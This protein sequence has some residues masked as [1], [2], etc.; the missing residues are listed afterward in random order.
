M[1]K[2]DSSWKR[3]QIDVFKKY[4]VNFDSDSAKYKNIFDKIKK[5]E[6]LD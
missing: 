3:N 4:L 6:R 2:N 1:K 5:L